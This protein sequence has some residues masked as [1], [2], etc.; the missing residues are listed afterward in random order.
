LRLANGK[1]SV[2]DGATGLPGIKSTTL[3]SRM[4]SLG[5]EKPK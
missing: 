1:I 4:K 3:A 2:N 5:V